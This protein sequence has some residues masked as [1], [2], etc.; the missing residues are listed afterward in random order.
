MSSSP[1][2]F[3]GGDL[4]SKTKPTARKRLTTATNRKASS[5]KKPVDKPEPTQ[6]VVERRI[7]KPV[8]E[9]PKIK[10]ELPIPTATFYF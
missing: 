9:L 10:G 5:D 2:R 6:Q 1:S 8:V 7:A 3:P 4:A